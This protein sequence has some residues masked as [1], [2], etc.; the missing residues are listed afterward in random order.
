MEAIFL[1]GTQQEVSE[2]LAKLRSESS[3]DVSATVLVNE[4]GGKEANDQ[5]PGAMSEQFAYRVLTR[6]PLVDSMENVME[7]ISNA[8]PAKVPAGD[9]EKASNMFGRRFTGMMGAFGR[10]VA[11][12]DGYPD[13]T[14]YFV[15]RWEGKEYHYTFSEPV[16][17]A[18]RRYLSQRK[19]H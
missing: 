13:G 11:H 18:V 15:Q 16:L 2:A 4:Q 14:F 8:Y 10:R 1:R 5:A 7:T 9:L 17:R 6:I 3:S 19:T 12:T